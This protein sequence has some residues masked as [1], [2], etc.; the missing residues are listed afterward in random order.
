MNDPTNHIGRKVGMLT[1]LEIVP[2]P[3]HLFGRRRRGTFVRCACD[4]GNETVVSFGSVSPSCQK[5]TQS[6]GCL[7]SKRR[8][9]G[10]TPGK[11]FGWAGVYVKTPDHSEE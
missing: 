3:E 2:A 8:S 4:C 6:C 5:R 7:S 10:G 1:I 9:K 11:G